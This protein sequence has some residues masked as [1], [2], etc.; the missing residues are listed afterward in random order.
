MH[1]VSGAGAITRVHGGEPVRP[2]GLRRTEALEQVVK[3]PEQL[4][5]FAVGRVVMRQE[6]GLMTTTRL[7]SWN[8]P[9][10]V[11]TLAADGY[12]P[13]NTGKDLWHL[14]MGPKHPASCREKA[15][16]TPMTQRGDRRRGVSSN[17]C[18]R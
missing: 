7:H 8:D 12:L 1:D 11:A 14:S 15:H 3:L 4:D 16:D 2:R 5:Q 9:T 13:V 10:C 6:M 17:S 18:P